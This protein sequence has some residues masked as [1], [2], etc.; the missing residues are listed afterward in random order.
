[1]LCPHCGKDVLTNEQRTMRRLTPHERNIFQRLAKDLGRPVRT[2]DIIFAMYNGTDCEP[3]EARSVM[4]IAIMHMRRKFAQLGL[5]YRIEN[6]FRSY[7]MEV[8]G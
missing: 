2:D 8:T 1:M 7:S 6:H 5:P 4:T 3:K